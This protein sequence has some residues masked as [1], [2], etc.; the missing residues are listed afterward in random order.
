MIPLVR[1]APLIILAFVRAA[2][3]LGQDRLAAWPPAHRCAGSVRPAIHRSIRPQ[4]VLATTHQSAR[5]S[6]RRPDAPSAPPRRPRGDRQQEASRKA[7]RHA[8]STRESARRRPRSNTPWATSTT[9]MAATP[10]RSTTTASCSSARRRHCS[11]TSAARAHPHEFVSP[12]Q[13]GCPPSQKADFDQLIAVG[14]AKAAAAE[15]SAAVTCYE[16]ALLPVVV[17][18]AR[19]ANAFFL[20]GT[21]TVRLRSITRSCD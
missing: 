8:R 15:Y 5:P 9:K 2:P 12:E 10:T 17:A 16:A 20:I 19:R 3:A 14:D 6:L 18:K 7:G 4:P 21:R 11:A 13:A 1:V